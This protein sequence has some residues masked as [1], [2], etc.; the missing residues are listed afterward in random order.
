MTSRIDASVKSAP[1]DTV[2]YVN[3][4]ELGR[5]KTSPGV[6]DGDANPLILGGAM[7][8]PDSARVQ[9]HYDGGIDDLVVY[10]RALPDA[11]IAALAAG[12]VPRL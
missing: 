11:E 4:R 8:S 2:L 7:N 3:G 1:G 9:A 12:R 10:D 6:L 5:R